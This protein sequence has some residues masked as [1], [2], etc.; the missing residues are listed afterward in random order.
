MII[1]K[2]YKQRLFDRKHNGIKPKKKRKRERK[3]IDSD[4]QIARAM[5]RK[6]LYKRS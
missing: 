4:G 3:L 1:P 5:Q 6:I 2:T